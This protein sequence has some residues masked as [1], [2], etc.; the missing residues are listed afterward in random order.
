VR[1]QRGTADWPDVLCLQWPVELE[2]QATSSY[3][4]EKY[5]TMTINFQCSTLLC[6]FLH[7]DSTL[8]DVLHRI[9]V[10]N[11][12]LTCKHY[13]IVSNSE[14]VECHE[15]DSLEHTFMEC[16]SS[17]KLYADIVNWFNAQHHMDINPTVTQILL[18][19]CQLSPV[20]NSILFRKISLLPQ[21]VKQH[22]YANKSLNKNLDRAECIS[23]LER[24][25]KIN[26]IV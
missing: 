19:F 12:E 25:W 16:T 2:I 10:T 11:K 4:P 6:V 1:W 13:G 24:T 14:C 21:H 26:K 7:M 3:E 9:L 22:I 18:N 20:S 23:K 17:L 5:S 8:S 15:P